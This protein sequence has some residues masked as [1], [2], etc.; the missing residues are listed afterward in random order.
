MLN[1]LLLYCCIMS[2]ILRGFYH[3]RLATRTTLLEFGGAFYAR[4][5]IAAFFILL[6]PRAGIPGPGYASWW[7]AYMVDHSAIIWFLVTLPFTG[8]IYL[9]KESTYYA[10]KSPGYYAGREE[11]GESPDLFRIDMKPS[12]IWNAVFWGWMFF[13]PWL[14]FYSCF[15]KVFLFKIPVKAVFPYV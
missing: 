6:G 3:H 11:H 8:V 4:A 13:S 10:V 1:W 15:I 7:S 5:F 9:F 14:P 12:L 2:F